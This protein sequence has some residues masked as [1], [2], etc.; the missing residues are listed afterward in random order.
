MCIPEGDLNSFSEGY[1]MLAT[2]CPIC[3][4]VELQDRQG[5]KY[6]VAC[7][8]VIVTIAFVLGSFVTSQQVNSVR[9]FLHQVDCHETSKDNPALSQQAASGV[10]AFYT[11]FVF[12]KIRQMFA[13]TRGG[14]EERGR[15]GGGPNQFDPN[16]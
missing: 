16:Q 2:L 13:I 15:V 3:E 8:E 4:C 1:R 10:R 14:L 12:A 5:A 11:L 7:Q 9:Y 6:C